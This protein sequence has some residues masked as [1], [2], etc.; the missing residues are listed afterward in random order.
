MSNTLAVNLNQALSESGFLTY[1]SYVGNQDQ[2][3][4][5][6][7]ALAQA[8]ALDLVEDEW[9]YLT[10]QG[11]IV[12]T[13]ATTYPLPADFLGFAPNTVYQHG[14]WDQADLPTTAEQWALL[15]SITGMS[16]LPIRVRL[17]NNQFNILNPQ[18]G[19]TINFEYQSKYPILAAVT[20]PAST[21]SGQFVSDADIWMLDD[22]MFQLNFKW[23]FKREKGLE[24]TSAK[25]ESDLWEGQ[26][27]A[28]DQ[29]N[30]TITSNQTT[31]MGVPYT[32]TWVI[33]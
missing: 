9:M 1:D 27:R 12:L 16:S 30:S 8:A 19:A 14:R 26:V 24:W 25:M 20:L 3:V 4:M 22:R 31:V 13:T 7:V 18:A 10:R 33:P 11:S 28:R 6:I 23:R 5:Q 29:G 15:N 17:L 2:N 32:N 21:P